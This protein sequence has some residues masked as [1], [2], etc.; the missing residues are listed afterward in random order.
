MTQYIAILRG[1]N[2]GG[3]RK[4][5]M[6]DLKEL[7]EQLGGTCVRT[8]IQSG[9]VV[10]D[11]SASTCAHLENL[12]SEAIVV[13]YGF[14]VPV[15]IRTSKEWKQLI[16]MIPFG[17]ETLDQLHV[18]F[19]KAL[20]GEQDLAVISKY[21]SFPDTFVIQDKQVYIQCVGSYH[22]TKL[23]NAFFEKKL[24]VP[25][26]TRSMKTVLKIAEMLESIPQ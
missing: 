13:H 25:C 4:V 24:K 19:L 12:L 5:L 18:I 20:P 23:G 1:I 21:D 22:K 14:E 2:V 3:K 10:F 16:Q 17:H 6:K 15:I 11:Y 9:N 26:S 7:V 8:Y